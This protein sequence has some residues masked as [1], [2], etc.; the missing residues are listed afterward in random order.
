[1][2]IPSRLIAPNFTGT[3]AQVAHKIPELGVLVKRKRRYY[4]IREQAI[5]PIGLGYA[6]PADPGGMFFV[7]VTTVIACGCVN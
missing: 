3:L 2:T 5:V 6:V 7:A 4:V 1:V